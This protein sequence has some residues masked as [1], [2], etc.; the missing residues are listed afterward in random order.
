MPRL[1]HTLDLSPADRDDLARTVSAVYEVLRRAR[2]DGTGELLLPGERERERLRRRAEDLGLVLSGEE[3]RERERAN[4]ERL[5]DVPGPDPAEAP[6]SDTEREL[7]ARDLADDAALNE[8]VPSLTLLDG[9]HL[10]PGS[11]YLLTEVDAE[12]RPVLDQGGEGWLGTDLTVTAW[13]ETGVCSVDFAMRGDVAPG[14][15]DI[16]PATRGNVVHDHARETL[17]ISADLSFPV[18]SALARWGSNLLTARVSARLDLRA[19]FSAA[20]GAAAD[21]PLTLEVEHRLVRGRAVAVPAPAPYGR[22]SVTGELDVRGRGLSRPLVAAAAWALLR[23]IRRAEGTSVAEHAAAFERDWDET[24]R[25]LPD[26]PGFLHEVAG[27]VAAAEP[28]GRD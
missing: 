25:A 18:Q 22:W 28:G 9:E 19:W 24:V 21:P 17:V 7:R 11:R 6:E 13:D 26:L 12:G 4:R 20:S 10:A 23:S 8:A 14:G 27:S 1:S 15:S 2:F 16:P 5:A 3:R